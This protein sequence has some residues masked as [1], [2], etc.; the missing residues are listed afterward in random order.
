[1]I[2]ENPVVMKGLLKMVK[3]FISPNQ[4]KEAV[5]SMIKTA[6]NYKDTAIELD[7]ERNEVEAAVILYEVE[8]VTYIGFIV[9]NSENHITRFEKVQ[10]LDSLV[11]Q[12]I[13]KL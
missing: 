5:N 9:L 11:D 10:T 13:Q 12:L 3:N 8:K 2:F 6:I 7:P 1:M 4:L